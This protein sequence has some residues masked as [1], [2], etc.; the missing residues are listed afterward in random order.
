MLNAMKHR[1]KIVCLNQINT[2]NPGRY[3]AMILLLVITGSAQAQPGDLDEYWEAVTRTVTEGDYEG[4]AALYHEDAVL[5]ST[6]SNS[7]VA[8]AKALAGWKQ[9]F[10]DT[11]EGKMTAGVTFRFSQRYSDE[12]T[13][14]DTGIFRYASTPAGGEEN[15]QYIHFEGLLVKKDGGWLM[16]M[17]YQKSPA[18]VEEWEALGE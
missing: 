13:A 12:T 16:V 17:E 6:F 5:V 9:G 7:S 10:M 8:I 11:K 18:T 15:A 2:L 14:H 3:L 4:Y 1:S